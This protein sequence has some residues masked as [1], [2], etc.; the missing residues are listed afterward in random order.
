MKEFKKKDLKTGYIVTFVNPTYAPSFILLGTANGD[1]IAGDDVWYPIEDKNDNMLFKY[2]DDT[3]IKEVYCPR[4]NSKHN[5]KSF[6]PKDEN[7]YKLIWK[8]EEKS[9][10]QKKVEELEATIA[11]AQTQLAQLKQQINK[12]E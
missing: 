1:I 2:T 4:Y 6:N 5:L 11:Q 12:G 10:E 9:S 3:S 8:R 7:Y